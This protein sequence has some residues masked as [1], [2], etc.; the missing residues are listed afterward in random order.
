MKRFIAAAAAIAL[1]CVGLVAGSIASA[2]AALS[3][4]TATQLALAGAKGIE[5]GFNG[6]STMLTGAKVVCHPQSATVFNCADSW[7]VVAAAH[8]AVAIGDA[9]AT[10]RV[11][12]VG[13]QPTV[14]WVGNFQAKNYATG[15][16]VSVP[17]S[18]LINE[19][20][21][22]YDAAAKELAHTAEV[23]VETYATDNKGSYA[24]LTAKKARQ[25]EDTIQITASPT[26]AFLSK[27]EATVNS[28]SLTVTA[29]VTKH[30]FTITRSTSGVVARTCA[31]KNDGGCAKNGT[32]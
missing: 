12:L 6:S 21:M 24:G 31:P 9:G 2:G 7:N 8:P 3:Q 4:T 22:A 1:A 20:A 16:T 10:V 30:S 14:A 15:A 13:T 17:M 11:A 23:A 19:M 29:A 28:Y 5:A 25:Y 27:V 32:W 18:T 26:A